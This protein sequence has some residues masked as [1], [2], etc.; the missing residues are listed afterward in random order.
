MARPTGSKAKK[1]RA[2]SR[3][4]CKGP[5]LHSLFIEGLEDRRLLAIADQPTIDF[6]DLAVDSGPHRGSSL[7][8]QFRDG[9]SSPG[10][11]AAHSLTSKLEPEWALTPGMRRVDL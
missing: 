10:S 1:L 8:V 11:L 6:S 5:R 9:A 2:S 3:A 7:I 4:G